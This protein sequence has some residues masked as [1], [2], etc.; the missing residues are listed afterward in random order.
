MY[1]DNL[2]SHVVGP[3]KH[4]IRDVRRFL[5]I[6]E[7]EESALPENVA[8]GTPGEKRARKGLHPLTLVTSVSLVPSMNWS[9]IKFKIGC[10]LKY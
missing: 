4:C 8:E 1:A 9:F 7:P 6:W 2:K 3:I 5:Q 10:P